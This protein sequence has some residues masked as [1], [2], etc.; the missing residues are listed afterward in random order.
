MRAAIWIG[1]L[2]W[3]ASWPAWALDLPPDVAAREA[4]LERAWHRQAR[5]WTPGEWVRPVLRG[6]PIEGNAAEALSKAIADATPALD[7][8]KRDAPDLWF[9]FGPPLVDAPPEARALATRLA[10]IFDSARRTRVRWAPC[11]VDRCLLL[12]ENDLRE[13]VLLLRAAKIALAA[14]GTDAGRCLTVAADVMRTAQDSMAGR[15]FTHRMVASTIINVAYQRAQA[16]AGEATVEA[17]ARA[18]GDFAR[19]ARDWPPLAPSL[20][21]ERLFAASSVLIGL[22]AEQ[23]DPS[24]LPGAAFAVSLAAAEHFLDAAERGLPEDGRPT[25]I[26]GVDDLDLG[27]RRL[28]LGESELRATVGLLAVEMAGPDAPADV[29]DP[30]SGRPFERRTDPDG[31]RS[32]WSVGADGRSTPDEPDRG[33]DVWVDLDPD[34]APE[35]WSKAGRTQRT[36]QRGMV[37]EMP[38]IMLGGALGIDLAACEPLPD[39]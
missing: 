1:V 3:A 13:G 37:R 8:A 36:T 33:D 20:R 19:L 6:E 23:A 39:P 27:V 18:A 15:A 34:G 30:F 32:F 21:F 11:P 10:P 2:G 38:L 35:D 31:A 24:F 17:R 12:R 5:A 14:T 16:C 9:T 25:G 29:A 28:A 22:R 26:D 4:A 7:E